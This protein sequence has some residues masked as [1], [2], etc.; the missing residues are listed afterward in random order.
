MAI[1]RGVLREDAK[2]Y[3]YD[4][5]HLRETRSVIPAGTE[6][7]LADPVELRLTTGG[8]AQAAT[9]YGGP[10]DGCTLLWSEDKV[11]D[12]KSPRDPAT[13]TQSEL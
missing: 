13:Q 12:P 6:L 4:G 5:N 1:H 10:F 9:V 3:Q 8:R 7:E 11:S 2:V